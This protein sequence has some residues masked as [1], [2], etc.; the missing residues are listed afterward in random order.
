MAGALPA[1]ASIDSVGVPWVDLGVG[2]MAAFLIASHWRTG[3]AVHLD[4][5]MLDIA[6]TW[7]G[8]KPEAVSR[9]EPTYG[10]FR[11]SDGSTFALAL[12]EDDMWARLCAALRLEDWSIE[13]GFAV[14][15]A[16]VAEATAVRARVQ[17]TLGRLSHAEIVELAAKH[18][19]PLDEVRSLEAA[20]DDPQIR[21]R[22]MRSNQRGVL[23]FGPSV[24]TTIPPFSD[25]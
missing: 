21:W 20:A 6:S 2:T 14:Y 1:Q 10:T 7:A 5:A 19:L 24:G 8:V 4:L 25:R 22:K 9:Q 23:P 18:D 15:S 12:L 13:S 16:R 17:E 11:S 3:R